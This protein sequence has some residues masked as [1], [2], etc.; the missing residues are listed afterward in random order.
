MSAVLVGNLGSKFD[1]PA[2]VLE[3][4][5]L[6]ENLK[7]DSLLETLAVIRQLNAINDKI[8]QHEWQCV[9]DLRE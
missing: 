1:L 6:W 8:T 3:K 2:F 4:P 9:H 7:Q 5:L